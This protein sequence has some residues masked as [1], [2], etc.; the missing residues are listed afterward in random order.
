MKKYLTIPACVIAALS[1]L[2]SAGATMR[3]A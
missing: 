3:K 2:C 1:T